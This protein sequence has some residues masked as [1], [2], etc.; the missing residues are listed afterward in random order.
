MVRKHVVIRIVLRDELLDLLP[1]LQA[2]GHAQVVLVGQAPPD[3]REGR[4]AAEQ[5][6]EI[7]QVVL[8]RHVC[9]TPPV[10]RMEQ[11]QISLDTQVLQTQQLVLEGVPE[12][13]AGTVHVP[14]VDTGVFRVAHAGYL[15]AL[16]CLEGQALAGRAA[17]EGVVPRIVVVVVVVLREDAQPDFIKRSLRERLEGLVHQRLGLVRQ[18]VNRGAEAVEPR[19][20]R[21]L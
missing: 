8:L 7:D 21:V 6:I 2:F 17:L 16:L 1:V 10:V 19:P 14:V 18:G 9:K 13:V 15:I 12:G 11:N 20:V 4:E 5:V 3:I